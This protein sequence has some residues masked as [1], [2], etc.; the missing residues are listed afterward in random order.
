MAIFS[1][2]LGWELAL[3]TILFI[4]AIAFCAYKLLVGQWSWD[5]FTGKET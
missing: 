3:G 5:Y 4:I 1:G 2:L